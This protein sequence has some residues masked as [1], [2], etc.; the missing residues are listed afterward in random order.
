[1]KFHNRG[2]QYFQ[3]ENRIL[4]QKQWKC[5][6]TSSGGEH[7]QDR[8]NMHLIAIGFIDLSLARDNQSINSYL[9]SRQDSGTSEIVRMI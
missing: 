3:V 9:K 8:L 6:Q 5:R 7:T 2:C 4:V 1:M